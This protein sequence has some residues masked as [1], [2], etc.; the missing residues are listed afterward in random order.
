[1]K[2]HKLKPAK[3]CVHFFKCM[4]EDDCE[5]LAKAE[6]A[7]LSPVALE[8][9]GKARGIDLDRRKKKAT[10]INELYEAM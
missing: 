8:A 6:L 1:M 7:E 4:W 2:K 3:K 10:L 5:E 9:M